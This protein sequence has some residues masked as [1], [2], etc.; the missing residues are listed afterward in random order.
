MV[1]L[2]DKQFADQCGKLGREWV[3]ENCDYVLVASKQLKAY[4]SVLGLP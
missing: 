4:N 3:I 2:E 1:K